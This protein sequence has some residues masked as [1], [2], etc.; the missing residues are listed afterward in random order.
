MLW[1]PRISGLSSSR[2]ISETKDHG[3]VGWDFI[4]SHNNSDIPV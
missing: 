3:V 2:F 1:R 4:H